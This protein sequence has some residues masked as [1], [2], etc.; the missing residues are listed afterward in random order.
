MRSDCGLC[1]WWV[2]CHPKSHP[3]GIA[4]DF[5]SKLLLFLQQE[6]KTVADMRE[7][8]SSPVLDL[9]KE[10]VRAISSLVDICNAAPTE[11]HGYRN[12]CMFSG[13]KP[14]PSSEEEYDAWVEM[15]GSVLIL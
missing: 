4:V 13:V 6:G 2:I 10:L 14:T 12:L 15:S 8:V 1:T 9:N 5:Q 11:G 7:I 3:P